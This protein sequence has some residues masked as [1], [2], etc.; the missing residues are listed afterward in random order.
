MKKSILVIFIFLYQISIAQDNDLLN[1]FPLSNGKI[2]YEH[3]GTADSLT[4]DKL[5][6]N[7]KY[8]ISETFK[9]FKA[10]VQLEDKDLGIINAKGFRSYPIKRLGVVTYLD[11]YHNVKISVKDKKYKVEIYDFNVD[12]K[13]VRVPNRSLELFLSQDKWGK[14]KFSKEIDSD[15]TLYIEYVI[16]KMNQKTIDNW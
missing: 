1:I 7:A 4:K 11:V 13:D 12:F 10:T 16:S 14:E 6:I 9:S 15:I 3:I 8:I 5:Y 2:V